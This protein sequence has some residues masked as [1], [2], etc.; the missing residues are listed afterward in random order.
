MNPVSRIFARILSIGLVVAAVALL[1]VG[2]LWLLTA[3]GSVAAEELTRWR[4]GHGSV[5]SSTGSLSDFANLAMALFVVIP[6]FGYGGLAVAFARERRIPHISLSV[7]Q[8]VLLLVL[9]I[10]VLWTLI[11]RLV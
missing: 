1:A 11:V 4:V 7:A 5:T 9:A 3:D 10:P 2:I 6:I 8:I